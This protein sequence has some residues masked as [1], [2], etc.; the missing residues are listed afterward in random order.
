[1]NINN[2]ILFNKVNSNFFIIKS[3]YL[4][5]IFVIWKEKEKTSFILK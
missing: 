1:M 4:S 5:L 2:I 3:T